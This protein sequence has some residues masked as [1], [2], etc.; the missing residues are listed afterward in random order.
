M[1]R[2]TLAAIDAALALLRAYSD[3][4]SPSDELTP[5]RVARAV[6]RASAALPSGTSPEVA[7]AL[8]L[9]QEALDDGMPADEVAL[10]LMRARH[11]VEA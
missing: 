4:L 6:A 8:S 9:A 7:H 5:E 10:L 2:E 3:A 1:P 11:M